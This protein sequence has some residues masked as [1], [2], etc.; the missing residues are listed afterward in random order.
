MPVIGNIY[1]IRHKTC[2][3][4]VES[5]S[6]AVGKNFSFCNSRFLLLAARVST[7]K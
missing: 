5:S 6:P 1:I 3:S 7:C 4:G 2:D